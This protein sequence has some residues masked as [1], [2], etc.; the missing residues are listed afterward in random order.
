MRDST[1][2]TV[3]RMGIADHRPRNIRYRIRKAAA[4]VALKRAGAVLD[5]TVLTL[6]YPPNAQ[7]V[8]RYAKPLQSLVERIAAGDHRYSEVLAAIGGYAEDLGRIEHR[9]DDP[10]SPSWINGF[11]PGLDSAAIYAFLRDRDPARYVEIGSGNSTMFAAR[12]RADG[13]LATH[14]TSVDPFPR[15]EI[16]TLCDEVIRLPFEQVDQTVF[17]GLTAGDIVFMDGSHRVF[18]NNDVVAFFLETLPNLPSG[19]LVGI[20]D[21]YLPFDYPSEIAHRYYSEQYM[22]A[23]YLLGRPP[24]DIVLP[25]HYAFTALRAEVEALWTA[26]PRFE[27]IERHGVAFWL[28]TR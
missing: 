9:D 15:A 6:D 18:M 21:V 2:G 4:E 23:A 16:D 28:E 8:P 25:A 14:F 3:L 7:N 22:L 24:L 27:G 17:R 19:V 5:K 12:A 10:L 13:G 20:H 1:T 26:S 11:L